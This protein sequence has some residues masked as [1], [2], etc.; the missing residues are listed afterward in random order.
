MA[1]FGIPRQEWLRLI[2]EFVGG[3]HADRGKA[4]WADKTPLL[5]RTRRPAGGDLDPARTWNPT[6]LRTGRTPQRRP[7]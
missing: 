7:A 4:R 2:R 1:R 3:I 5:A 6:R